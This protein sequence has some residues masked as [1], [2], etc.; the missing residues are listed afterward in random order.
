MKKKI[1]IGSLFAV[2]FI[3]AMVL[4]IGFNTPVFYNTEY[5][6]YEQGKYVGYV[7]IKNETSLAYKSIS[8]KEQSVYYTIKNNVLTFDRK[9]F[10]IKSKFKLVNE[11]YKDVYARPTGGGYST[12]CAVLIVNLTSLL[13]LVSIV[14]VSIYKRQKYITSQLKKVETLENELLNKNSDQ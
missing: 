12:Y 1:T 11:D 5:S 4:L 10:T 2:V 13:A 7:Y 8:N 9:E 6:I 14:G 3:T